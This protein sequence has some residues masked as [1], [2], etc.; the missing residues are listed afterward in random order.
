MAPEPLVVHQQFRCGSSMQAKSR[1]SSSVTVMPVLI[2]IPSQTM[3]RSN[4]ERLLSSLVHPLP[5]RGRWLLQS[6]AGT[7]HVTKLSWS[8]L[9]KF[10]FLAV[11]SFKIS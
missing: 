1:H 7:S 11:S 5:W 4:G 8:G 6:T 10:G 9:P 2:H 3:E